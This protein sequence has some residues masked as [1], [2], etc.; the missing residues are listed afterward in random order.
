[1]KITL[2]CYRL[3]V[4]NKKVVILSSM[5]SA[6]STHEV[7]GKE[8]INVY[9]NETKGKVDSHDPNVPCLLPLEKQTASQCGFFTEF[10]IVP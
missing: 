10:Q 5:H 2:H 4:K 9:N 8:E 7:T 6:Y 1:M 3:H